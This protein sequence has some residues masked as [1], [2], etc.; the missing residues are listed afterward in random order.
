MMTRKKLSANGL[1]KQVMSSFGKIKEHRIGEI[2][3]ESGV[4]LA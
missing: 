4:Q 2:K 3:L 1:L